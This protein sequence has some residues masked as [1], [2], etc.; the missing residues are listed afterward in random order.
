MYQAYLWTTN[1]KKMNIHIKI[2]QR[3]KKGEKQ[4]WTTVRVR[5]VHKNVP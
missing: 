1:N 5:G 4:Q 2:I 3:G